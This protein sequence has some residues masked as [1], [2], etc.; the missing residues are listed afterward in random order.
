M[1]KSLIMILAIILLCCGCTA[2]YTLRINEDGTVSEIVEGLE[3]VDFYSRYPNSSVQHV[4]GFLVEPHL[5]Y[6]NKHNYKITE[7]YESE[8]AG[9]ILTNKFDSIEKYLSTSKA[10]SQYGSEIEYTEKDGYI[11]LK[12]KGRLGQ[13]TQEQTDQMVIEEAFI[14]I[15]LPNRKV[16]SH[17]ADSIDEET[18]TY[19]WKVNNIDEKE[20][21]ITFAKD[22][23]K[24]FPLVEII[25]IVAF[26]VFFIV[27]G[28]IAT[29]IIGRKDS[30]NRV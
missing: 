20:L 19:T 26:V 14:N 25:A 16:K 4:I 10:A 3:G 8:N 21:T 13:E 27:A 5:D 30:R 24:Y 29:K 23:N 7:V 9:V 28:Y 15:S 17:N 1:K 22:A 12:I 2:D 6:L 18:D 11:T